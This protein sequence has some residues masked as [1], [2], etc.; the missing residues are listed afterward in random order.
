VTGNPRVVD[1]NTFLAKLQTLEFTS[2]VSILR[3]AQRVWGRILTMSGVVTALRKSAL[4][5]A[6][7]FSPEMATEDIDLTW[8][9]QMRYYD[10]RYEP[11][12]VVWMHVP[13]TL[14]ALWKQRRRWA[15]GLSQVL[16]RHG[17]G[18]VSWRRRR[19]WPV[20]IESVLSIMWAYTFVVMAALWAMSYALG[21]PPVGA[22]PF[23]NWWGMVIATMSVAQL[24]TG[25][26]LDRRYDRDVIRYFPY[27]VFYPLVYWMLM[28]LVTVVSTPGGLLRAPSRP[29]LWRTKRVLRGE[30][31]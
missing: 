22:S 2:I 19:M 17:R 24:G 10:V 1:P 4:A 27:A 20:A 30:S 11:E 12:A 18:L 16:R 21:I 14:E 15:L 13:Q 6:G 31:A 7:L 25:I 26:L 8:K 23:P 3:R 9:L 28:A 29:T 5:D